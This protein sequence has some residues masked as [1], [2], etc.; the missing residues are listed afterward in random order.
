VIKAG[1]AQIVPQGGAGVGTGAAG[2]GAA[3]VA[4]RGQRFAWGAG[5]IGGVIVGEIIDQALHPIIDSIMGTSDS[6]MKTIV[7]VALQGTL[8]A[9]LGALG[10]KIASMMVGAI[11]TRVAAGAAQ[12]AATQAA[13][14]AAGTGLMAAMGGGGIAAAGAAILGIVTLGIVG[15]IAAYY[16]GKRSAEG[17]SEARQEGLKV[18]PY[19]GSVD[20]FGNPIMYTDPNGKV[21]S[22]NDIDT[23]AQA[24]P[25]IVPLTPR[26]KI[27][28]WTSIEALRKRY[29]EDNA[30]LA[31]DRKRQAVST[32]PEALA[33]LLK[34]V[35]DTQDEMKDLLAC[36]AHL[37]KKG[38]DIQQDYSN[39]QSFADVNCR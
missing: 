4:A 16:V 28:D 20:D 19:A 38:N 25:T 35:N 21:T 9:G 8:D 1:I 23:R 11:A 34:D 10:G 39:R 29:D 14:S 6:T 5:A 7:E 2:A 22:G 17:Q 30:R 12:A 32:T 31:D 27:N 13:G 18:A 15:A 36:I 37:T 3:P 24:N 33:A 26:D